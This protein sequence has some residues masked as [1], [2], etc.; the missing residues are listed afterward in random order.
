MVAGVAV[1]YVILTHQPKTKEPKEEIISQTIV[2]E[3]SDP[4]KDKY[5]KECQGW[6][7][8]KTECENI[9]AKE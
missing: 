8:A 9:W 6:G 2:Q 4:I 7:I 3:K 1:V 5:L